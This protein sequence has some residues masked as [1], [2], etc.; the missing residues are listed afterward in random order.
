MDHGLLGDL[1]RRIFSLVARVGT[2][3]WPALGTAGKARRAPPGGN[4]AD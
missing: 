4:S 2:A 1:N 3:D